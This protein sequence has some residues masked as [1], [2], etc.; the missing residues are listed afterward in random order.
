MNRI[1][2]TSALPYA[3]GFV[4]LGHL[5]GAYL[6]ADIYARF[7]RLMGKEV[8]YICGS[9]EHGAAITIAAE[10]EKTSPKHIIDKYHFA[11][12]EAFKKF[13]MSFDFYSR[14][15]NETHHKVAL[16]FFERM[17]KNG[18]LTEKT[19]QQFFD[20]KTKM[21]LPDRYVEGTCPVCGFD[22]A[23]GDQCDKCGAYYEQT[24]LIK[25]V[26]IVSGT[27]PEVKHTIH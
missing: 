27:T 17:L 23:R 10:Y 7:M 12:L 20:S 13:G 14:T 2:I 18:F 5:A 8:L 24:Q 3:N 26:S 15:S 9:D 22:K 1:L 4:H 25:P 19:D 16:E 6:P 21:F 11:N